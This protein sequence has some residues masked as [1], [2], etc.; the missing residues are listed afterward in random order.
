MVDVSE[1]KKIFPLISYSEI[2]SNDVCK[3]YDIYNVSIFDHWLSTEECE[4]QLTPITISKNNRYFDKER[5]EEAYKKMSNFY[6]DLYELSS[7]IIIVNTY[8][9]DDKLKED[10]YDLT[11]LSDKKEYENIVNRSIKKGELFHFLFYEQIMMYLSGHDYT[12]TIMI[13]KGKD[14]SFL[15]KIA[16]QNK[17]FII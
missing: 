9:Y 15:K 8:D 14:I 16:S 11:L 4:K 5:F 13:Q 2:E 7:N 1:I 3:Y 12:D 6:N 17:L 10:K